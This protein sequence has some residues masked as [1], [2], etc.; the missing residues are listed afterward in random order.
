MRFL[1]DF[2]DFLEMGKN[3][4]EKK[5][6]DFSSSAHN[7]R[8]EKQGRHLGRREEGKEYNWKSKGG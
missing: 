7:E 8:E 2:C 3:K 6:K 1:F 5:G 4:K